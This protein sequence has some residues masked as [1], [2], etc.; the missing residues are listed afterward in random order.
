MVINIILSQCYMVY[1]IQRGF[2]FF[3]VLFLFLF[4]FSN[5]NLENILTFF[6]G[7]LEKIRK[8]PLSKQNG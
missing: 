4:F 3:F 7:F 6:K 5:V 1:R 8:F 2:F